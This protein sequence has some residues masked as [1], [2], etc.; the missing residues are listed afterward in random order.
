MRKA[1]AM[2]AR[3]LYA[4]IVFVFVLI[5]NLHY[6]QAAGRTE[7]TPFDGFGVVSLVNTVKTPVSASI[8]DDAKKLE[9]AGSEYPTKVLVYL[10]GYLGDQ[11]NQD[12]VLGFVLPKWSSWKKT[13]PKS[14]LMVC[15][16]FPAWCRI[17]P[18]DEV[19]DLT[20]IYQA[21]LDSALKARFFDSISTVLAHVRKDL[22]DR[23]DAVKAR[24]AAELAAKKALA[25]AELARS[26]RFEQDVQ[27]AREVLSSK[28]EKV[29]SL[30]DEILEFSPETFSTTERLIADAEQV[31]LG[32]DIVS[33]YR[34]AESL[35]TFSEML[36]QSIEVQKKA[37]NTVVFKVIV[38]IGLLCILAVT[39]FLFYGKQVRTALV[40][41]Q[42][43]EKLLRDHSE[44]LKKLPLS[45]V[46]DFE[47]NHGILCG[48]MSRDGNKTLLRLFQFRQRSS[49]LRDMDVTSSSF[50]MPTFVHAVNH[51]CSEWKAFVEQMEMISNI[52]IRDRIVDRVMIF[53]Q[54]LQQLPD[55]QSLRH[56]L[57]EH[58][59]YLDYEGK[60]SALTLRKK[61]D[62]ESFWVDI[63]A[64]EFLVQ[65]F[66]GQFEQFLE[67]LRRAKSLQGRVISLRDVGSSDSYLT[68]LQIPSTWFSFAEECYGR[69]LS[70]S[71]HGILTI[72]QGI[73]YLKEY[74]KL[75]EKGTAL[76]QNFRRVAEGLALKNSELESRLKDL[77]YQKGELAEWASGI[78]LVYHIK[79]QAT[80][81]ANQTLVADALLNEADEFYKL[82]SSL[83]S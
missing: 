56:F 3:F 35:S 61:V 80:R 17:F 81:V 14:T 71:V 41:D 58:P 16:R 20:S 72:E 7:V 50:D 46:N 21:E 38:Y 22:L 49:Q 6:S 77:S 13:H 79:V 19:R 23:D 63:Q 18:A 78:L 10:P 62:P 28:I 11:K 24:V 32:C 31:K 12:Y 4:A 65:S 54:V 57:Q 40:R 43:Q 27:S 39:L 67:L 53:R 33:L 76:A 8:R 55:Y 68:P 9:I 36:I 82:F 48:K 1:I 30:K 25:E 60:M 64:L 83:R 69:L 51:L 52:N 26:M 59:L 15:S 66:E 45:Q 5:F 47:R 37:E 44:I 75:L 42:K 29:L 34:T 70:G 74:C 2:F 73:D